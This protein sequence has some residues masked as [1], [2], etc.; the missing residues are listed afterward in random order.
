MLSWLPVSMYTGI[1]DSALGVSL[2]D[3]EWHVRFNLDWPTP[4][5][6]AALLLALSL[7][8]GYSR[9]ESNLLS[10]SAAFQLLLTRGS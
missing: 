1:V 7:A 6:V 5:L 2:A 9:I 10:A 8:I 4:S 3:G